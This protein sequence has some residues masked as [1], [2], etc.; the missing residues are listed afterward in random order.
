MCAR[1]EIEGRRPEIER[2]YF[3]DKARRR[4]RGGEGRRERRKRERRRYKGR[5]RMTKAAR[6]L[7]VGTIRKV[8]EYLMQL[9]RLAPIYRDLLALEEH[10]GCRPPELPRGRFACAC[11]RNSSDR[12]TLRMAGLPSYR[13]NV[14]LYEPG[15]GMPQPESRQSRRPLGTG[16]WMLPGSRGVFPADRRGGDSRRSP[17]TRRASLY[18]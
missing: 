4:S 10:R 12:P 13:A 14:L 5:R 15:W 3:G 2:R 6:G 9:P 7:I 16:D 11:E 18:G 17:S 8:C 1:L